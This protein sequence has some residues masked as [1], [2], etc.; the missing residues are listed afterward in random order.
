MIDLKSGTGILPQEIIKRDALT[1]CPWGL[2]TGDELGR[3]CGEQ[4]IIEIYENKGKKNGLC[5]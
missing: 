2:T 3:G 5:F 1:P 4:C